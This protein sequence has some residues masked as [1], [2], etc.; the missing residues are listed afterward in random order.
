[1]GKIRQA[2]AGFATL[3]AVVFAISL[4]SDKAPGASVGVGPSKTVGAPRQNLPGQVG[5]A[6]EQTERIRLNRNRDLCRW[7]RRS[8][9]TFN[10]ALVTSLEKMTRARDELE[11]AGAPDYVILQVAEGDEKYVKVN[12]AHSLG[13]IL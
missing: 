9:T 7:S 1:M 5:L 6:W 8:V 2:A 10:V 11:A 13:E 12:R 3:I 4:R